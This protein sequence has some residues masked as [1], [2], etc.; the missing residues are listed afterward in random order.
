M[1][2]FLGNVIKHSRKDRSIS[3][4]TAV[5]DIS[6]KA[7]IVT[8]GRFLFQAYVLKPAIRCVRRLQGGGVN[9]WTS[10]VVNNDFKL[11]VWEI[12]D[13]IKHATLSLPLTID[14]HSF[15]RLL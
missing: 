13:R 7:L 3:A 2:C 8:A 1:T 14:N 10:G 5:S 11:L 15:K 4:M 9:F 6:N 12:W